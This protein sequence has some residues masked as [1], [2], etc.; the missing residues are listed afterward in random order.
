VIT[1]EFRLT[2]PHGRCEEIVLDLL[3]LS[4]AVYDVCGCSL[5]ARD[6]TLQSQLAGVDAANES[7]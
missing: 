2:N 3:N 5:S 4:N 1:V 6:G 7:V